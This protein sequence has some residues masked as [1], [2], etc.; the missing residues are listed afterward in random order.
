MLQ[1]GSVLRSCLWLSNTPLCGYN[2]ILIIHS[3]I[4]GHLGFS[5]ILALR[6]NAMNIHVQSLYVN[7]CFHFSSMYYELELLG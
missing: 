5:H 3:L 2:H 1:H 6:K 7:L 4:N